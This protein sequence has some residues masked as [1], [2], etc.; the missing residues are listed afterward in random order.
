M[1]I[2]ILTLPLHAN[3]GGILQ[4]YAL[5]TVLERMGHEVCVLGTEFHSED[6]SLSYKIRWALRQIKNILTNGKHLP[7]KYNKAQLEMYN[8]RILYTSY[9]IKNHIHEKIVNSLGDIKPSDFDAIIVGSDQIWNTLI[10]KGFDPVF[11]ASDPQFAA[12]RNIAYAA[13]DGSVTLSEKDQKTFADKMQRF[14][15]I[16]V[17]EETLQRMLA[18]RGIRA[19]INLDPV[20]LAGRE[21][22]DRIA[23]D[24]PRRKPFVLTYEAVDHPEVLL[25][26]HAIAREAGLQVISIARTPY[27][28]G[29]ARYSPAEFA[30]L[31]RDARHVVTT[32]FHGVALSLLYHT[33]FTFVPTGTRLDER[34]NHILALEA[35]GS[36]ET[37]RI[38]S[39]EYL[40][41]NL[42]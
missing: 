20:L 13:S 35:N 34:I 25:K 36:L 33:P 6:V 21:V 4:A 19:E 2:G 29:R 3:Y 10:D 8:A 32:S 15:A 5:Q 18:D 28:P 9:F 39:L 22:V 26:A 31:V 42:K 27:R 17:R 12:T 23:A 7:F 37:I 1:R 41:N 38:Q 14:Q 11:F 30:A 40:K 16:G 24:V